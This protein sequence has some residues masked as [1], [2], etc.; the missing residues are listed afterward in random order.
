MNPPKYE[1]E[2]QS[3]GNIFCNSTE[4]FFNYFNKLENLNFFVHIY[5]LLYALKNRN[6]YIY[7]YIYT[8]I[9]LNSV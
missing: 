2:R 7:A 8:Y 3:V 9:E 5:F 4:E 6:M 1:P